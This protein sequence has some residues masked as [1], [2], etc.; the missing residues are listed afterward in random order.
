M[1][2]RFMFVAML[3]AVPGLV[4]AQLG[5]LKQKAGRSPARRQLKRPG[6]AQSTQ[7]YHAD[8]Y[9]EATIGQELDEKTFDAA[10]RGM[11]AVQN[12]YTGVQAERVRLSTRVNGA[13][14]N[15]KTTRFSVAR[16]PRERRA[17]SG[18]LHDGRSG[19][20]PGGSP[21]SG[22]TAVDGPEIN[23]SHGRLTD[24]EPK[25]AAW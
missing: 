17:V 6:S 11:N 25:R 18:R 5:K 23:S 2:R 20:T 22:D 24:S 8:R 21:G 3:L 16:T 1:L 13:A 4:H 10:L 19:E 7:T 9:T 14:A 15:R 12:E